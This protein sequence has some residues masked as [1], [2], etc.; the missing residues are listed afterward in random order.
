VTGIH[1]PNVPSRHAPLPRPAASGRGPYFTIAA[2]ASAAEACAVL[3]LVDL[4]DGA[5]REQELRRVAALTSRL[6]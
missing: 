5:T 3:D 6:R 2:A 1:G 4:S